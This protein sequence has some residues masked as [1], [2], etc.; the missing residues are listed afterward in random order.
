MSLVESE[1]L[2]VKLSLC[3]SGLAW[4]GWST[5]FA[6]RGSCGLDEDVSL[7][8]WEVLPSLGPGSGAGAVPVRSSIGVRGSH[9]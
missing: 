6:L 2:G 9:L 1:L 7:A 4:Q 8:E 3:V 5:G